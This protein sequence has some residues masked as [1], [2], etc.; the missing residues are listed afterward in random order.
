MLTT[1][2][3]S[4]FPLNSRKRRQLT[5]AMS[6]CLGLW[7]QIVQEVD[8]DSFPVF[9]EFQMLEGIYEPSAAE[10][11]PDGRVFVVEDKISHSLAILTIL[12]NGSFE[13]ERL[14]AKTFFAPILDKKDPQ[15]PD[16]LEGIAVDDEGF[17]YI[18]TSHSRESDGLV[19]PQREQLIRFKLDGSKPKKMA[20]YSNLK[21]DIAA[22]YAL[23]AESAEVTDVKN[24]GGFNIEG[25]AFD[26][27]KKS[28]LVGF[29]SP[30]SDGKAV[31]V[32]VEN[33]KD[34][35]V[36]GAKAK[37]GEKMT[38]LDMKN[39]GVRGIGYDPKLDGYLIIS[40]PMSRDR[41]LDF[42]L[43]FWNGKSGHDVIPVEIP[44]AD[45]VL[46]RGECVTSIRRNDQELV[47]LIRDDGKRKR[48]KKKYANYIFLTYG[49]LEME[50]Q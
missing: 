30:Q 10:Q 40:G 43:W 25:I 9:T 50:N 8:A 47:L 23:F 29:R 45:N 21:A 32:T 37:I 2:L 7:V 33:P 1:R 48:K 14:D 18:I 46:N 13:V 16:D 27:D 41:S 12:D 5:L 20:A 39:N 49:Q 11:M 38:L 36:E 24:K 34:L 17:V 3:N 22:R 28:M 26:K 4:P 44:G 6:L 15:I 31:L 35:F 42:G 19:Y